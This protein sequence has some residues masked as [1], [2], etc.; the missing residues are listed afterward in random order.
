MM[1]PQLLWQQIWWVLKYDGVTNMMRTKTIRDLKY[2]EVTANV[3]KPQILCNHKCDEAPSEW[4]LKYDGI[5]KIMRNQIWWRNC[6]YDEKSYVHVHKYDGTTNM[7]RPQIW[8]SPQIWWDGKCDAETTNVMGSQILCNCKY[9]ETAN[10]MRPDIVRA[11]M[12]WNHKYDGTTN[13]M[14]HHF[15]EAWIMDIN[16]YET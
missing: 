12:W 2:D 6:K 13:V 11:Q 8:C 14:L 4:H 15:L 3:M 10:I 9:D 5:A 16:L 7:M 1:E